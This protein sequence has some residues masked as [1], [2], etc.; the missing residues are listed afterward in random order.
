LF[1]GAVEQ[2]QDAEAI[3]QKITERLVPEMHEAFRELLRCD[4]EN[5]MVQEFVAE[6]NDR[7]YILWKECCEE[8]THSV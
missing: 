2:V 8:W 6:V 5:D 1:S 7:L 4:M 3:A